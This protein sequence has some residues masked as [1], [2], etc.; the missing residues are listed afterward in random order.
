MRDILQSRRFPG[1]KIITTKENFRSVVDGSVITNAQ[2]LAE[3]NKRNDVIDVREWG[4][5]QFCDLDAKKEREAFRAG[6]STKSKK[7]RTATIVE[8]IQKLEQG[9]VPPPR[10]NEDDPL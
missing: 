6:T 4:N 2:E 9:Y 7:Q 5:D 1:T 10:K 8:S 3:H